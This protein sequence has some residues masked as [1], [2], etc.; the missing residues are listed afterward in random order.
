MQFKAAHRQRRIFRPHA[1]GCRQ[2]VSRVI[3]HRRDDIRPAEE[4]AEPVEL[5]HREYHVTFASELFQLFIYKAAQVTGERHQRM[6]AGAEI[7]QA[8]R[9][10]HCIGTQQFGHAAAQHFTLGVGRQVG[11]VADAD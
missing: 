7:I 6:G 3:R 9:A 8:R 1:A 5:R 4:R 11:G 10:R 2:C